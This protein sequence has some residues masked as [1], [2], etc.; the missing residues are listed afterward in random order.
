M[1]IT[2]GKNPEDKGIL[3]GLR[4]IFSFTLD[5]DKIKERIEQFINK[6]E[7]QASHPTYSGSLARASMQFQNIVPDNTKVY[8]GYFVDRGHGLMGP[9]STIPEALARTEMHVASPGMEFF[10]HKMFKIYCG[11]VTI[12]KTTRKVVKQELQQVDRN[13]RPV[14]PDNVVVQE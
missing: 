12:D 2:N 14:A 10:K 5:L 4:D 1:E 11:D 13:G 8:S 6:K 3:G 9:Y 7:E